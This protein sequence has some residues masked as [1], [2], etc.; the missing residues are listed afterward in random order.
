MGVS[1]AETSIRNSPSSPLPP[2]SP[3]LL[4]DKPDKKS[5]RGMYTSRDIV[6]TYLAMQGIRAMNPPS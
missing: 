5:Q 6:E 4:A 2:S 3:L 1:P